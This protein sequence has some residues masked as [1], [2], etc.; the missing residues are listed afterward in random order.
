MRYLRH[1]EEEHQRQLFS[2]E[3]A[4]PHTYHSNLI[5]SFDPT[6]QLYV[7]NRPRN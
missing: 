6:S 4:H 1:Q 3:G 5:S 7:P 2:N